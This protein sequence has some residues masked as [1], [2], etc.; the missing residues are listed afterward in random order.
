MFEPLPEV[1]SYPKLEESILD[2]WENNNVFE[3]SQQARVGAEE[4]SFFEGPPTVN[5]KPGIHHVLA[6]TIKD[7]ICRYKHLRGYHVRRQAGWDTHGLPVELSAE[8]ELGI[9]DKA[10]IEVMVALT[11]MFA[12]DVSKVVRPLLGPKSS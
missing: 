10:Q 12:R 9:T 5:G 6:R 3:R 7:S 8:K 1:L 2:Y 11:K 4:F